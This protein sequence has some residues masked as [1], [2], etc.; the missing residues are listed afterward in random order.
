MSN[1]TG[2][3]VYGTCSDGVQC[4]SLAKNLTKQT[5]GDSFK[6]HPSHSRHSSKCLWVKQYC[7]W[8]NWVTNPTVLGLLIWVRLLCI[9]KLLPCFDREHWAPSWISSLH[10][11]LWKPVPSTFTLIFSHVNAIIFFLRFQPSGTLLEF[12][13]VIGILVGVFVKYLQIN[14]RIVP[15][16]RPFKSL[17]IQHLWQLL[18]LTW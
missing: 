14:S 6:G 10:F 5:V 8:P 12:C 16:N 11:T 17:P 13:A 7:R 9:L 2:Q 15:W 1:K 18:Q 4:C 3:Y